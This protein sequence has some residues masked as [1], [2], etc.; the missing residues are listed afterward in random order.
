MDKHKVKIGIYALGLKTAVAGGLEIYFRNLIKGLWE[1]DNKNEYYIFVGDKKIKKAIQPYANSH[2]KLIYYSNIFRIIPFVFI[3]LFAKPRTFLKLLVNRI[4]RTLSYG[5]IYDIDIRKVYSEIFRGTLNFHRYDIDAVHFPFTTIH[6]GYL[7]IDLPVILTVADIQQEYYP[8]FFDEKTIK[9]RMVSYRPSAERADVIIAI[10][11]YTKKTLIEKYKINPAKIVVAYIGCSKDFK[12]IDDGAVLNSVR[13][14]YDLPSEFMLYP[15]STWPHKNH[16]KLLEAVSILRSKYSLE[17]TLILTGIPKNNQK[18]IT[19]TI[20]RL[21]LKGLIKFLS[22]VPF[23]DLP[24]IYNLASIMVFPS[25]FEGFGIPLVEAMNVGLPIACSDRTSIPEVV[26]DAGIYF[27]PDSA[28]DIAEKIYQ[29]WKDEDLRKRLVNR[30]F[31]RAERFTWQKG[32]EMTLTAYKQAV[33][34]S[35]QRKTKKE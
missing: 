5:N 23:S 34:R 27:N 26:G 1:H 33:Q 31:E 21:E 11:E 2:I 3:I 35:A 19:E 20:E 6:P 18:N 17:K 24:I 32:I 7:N 28:E 30:G 12:K 13:S 4:S 29:L 14:R 9:G 25:L 16:I 8:E 15:A 22:F 10:S